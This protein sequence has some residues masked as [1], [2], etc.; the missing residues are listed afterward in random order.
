MNTTGSGYRAIVALIVWAVA[1]LGHG[2][3]ATLTA[4]SVAYADVAAAVAAAAA[5]D[6][7]MVPAGQA[8]WT[9]TLTITQGIVLCGAGTNAT[10]ITRTNESVLTFKLAVSA[11]FRVTKMAFKGGWNYP[12]IRLHGS[13]VSDAG[14]P[15]MAF[16]IDHCLFQGGRRAVNPRGL[17][18]GVVDHCLFLNSNIAVG[19]VGDNQ[20]AWERPIAPGT[21]DAVYI[22]DNRFVIDNGAPAEPNEQVYHQEGAR[23][24][25]RFNIFDGTANTARNSCFYDSHGNMS[26]VATN[27]AT[28]LD[29]RGQPVLEVYGNT[30]DAHHTYQF[31]GIRGGSVLVFSNA[32]TYASGGKPHQFRLT[33]EEGWQTAFFVP[34]RTQWPALD[35]HRNSFFWANTL[36]GAAITNVT[37]SYPLGSD[38]VFIQPGR[39]YWME[40]PGASN[41]SPPGVYAGY[42]PFTYPHPLVAAQDG[43]PVPVKPAPPRALRAAP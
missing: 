19:P 29:L 43:V 30:F 16:R 39:D 5:G 3:A 32:L 13:G 40:A 42:T 4:A 24:V 26:S 33:E 11:P 2:H 27:P 10:V 38:A 17:C 31:F 41:G 12:L 20:A 6:T 37:L 15:I 25:T 8:E 23:S 9:R 34:L 18:Y 1:S 21:G 28:W 22:E 7:V 14:A 35:Q 36:N